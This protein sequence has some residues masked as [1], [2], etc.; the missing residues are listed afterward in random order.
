[1]SRG[2]PG[3]LPERDVVR[4]GLIGTGKM[5]RAHSVGYDLARGVLGTRPQPVLAVACGRE[6]ERTRDFARRF[7]WQEAVCDWESV[8]ERSDVDVIDVCA[9]NDLHA[10]IALRALEAGKHVLVE[11]PLGRTVQEAERLW[12]EASG[13]SGQVAMV[14]FN[15]RFVPAVAALRRVLA[16]DGLGDVRQVTVRFFQDWLARRAAGSWRLDPTRAGSG[17][18]GDLGVHCFDLVNALAGKIR[19]LNAIV[20]R[21]SP[22]GDLDDSAQVLL[23]LDG[24][25]SGVV[26]VSRTRVGYKTDLALE[27]TG[28][29]GSAAWRLSRPDVL[30]LC[31]GDDGWHELLAT[32]PEVFPP[33]A[34]WWGAGHPLGFENSFAY[35][36]D[37]LL[38]ALAER[39]AS[40]CGFDAG[41]EAQRAVDAAL[42]S[43]ERRAWVEL[44][45][46]G[47]AQ[48]VG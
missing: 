11:K 24:G 27:L 9:P 30:R 10:A 21:D 3:S 16:D 22:G 12:A 19:A 15:Y 47:D 40:E 35:V 34:A 36:M 28:T 32:S 26:E 41:A 33:A 43:S 14:V 2:A 13:R 31:R 6:A 17:V 20:R 8:V 23:E 18:L 25:G 38:G 42:V 46:P 1:M 44:S 5:G 48:G 4:I 39:R 37:E 7:G 45:H 29:G